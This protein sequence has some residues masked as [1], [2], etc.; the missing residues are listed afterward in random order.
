M[1]VRKRQNAL[2]NT[3]RYMYSTIRNGERVAV[4]IE[5]KHGG[6]TWRADTPEE[7]IALRK[8]L[9]LEADDS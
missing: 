9:E 6:R 1:Y 2:D 3:L 7:A 5:F 4:A 8:Q